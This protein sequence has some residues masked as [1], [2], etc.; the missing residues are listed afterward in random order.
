MRILTKMTVQ[1]QPFLICF[2][3][4]KWSL[5]WIHHVWDLH[6][7]R[8]SLLVLSIFGTIPWSMWPQLLFVHLWNLHHSKDQW[9]QCLL[10]TCWCLFFLSMH[11]LKHAKGCLCPLRSCKD[12]HWYQPHIGK[13]PCH[14]L[15]D[16]PIH[17]WWCFPLL[18]CDV[19]SQA[20]KCLC[21]LSC[22]LLLNVVWSAWCYG[23]KL[24]YFFPKIL[25]AQ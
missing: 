22:W 24:K 7:S 10:S 19:Q 23:L 16:V 1:H 4:P 14:W 9:S 8:H 5:C 25:T 12:P 2:S 11:F 13:M 6:V 3:H 20:H 21:L 15:W 17:L 18:L